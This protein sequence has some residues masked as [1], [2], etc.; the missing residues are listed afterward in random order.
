MADITI[1]RG[2]PGG[3]KAGNKCRQDQKKVY[4]TKSYYRFRMVCV[5]VREVEITCADAW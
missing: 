3:K 1:R 4:F 2:L 5:N